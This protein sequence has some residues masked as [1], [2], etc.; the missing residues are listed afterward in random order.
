[1]ETANE[2]TN[3][4]NCTANNFYEP[5]LRPVF[6]PLKCK[7]IQKQ[8][9]SVYIGSNIL[10]RGIMADNIAKPFFSG[11]NNNEKNIVVTQLLLLWMLILLLKLVKFHHK[12]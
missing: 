3:M 1:M 2:L 8:I 7:Y 6:H 4:Y 12:K 5:L 9:V 10:G 11:Q